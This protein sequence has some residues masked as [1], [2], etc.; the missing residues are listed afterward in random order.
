MY[1]VL[2]CNWK[3]T[4]TLRLFYI[5]LDL[6]PR[7]LTYCSKY[8]LHHKFIFSEVLR[9]EAD[10]ERVANKVQQGPEDIALL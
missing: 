3:V 9:S 2:N 8:A 10:Y 5:F 7:F 1:D 4:S 6:D